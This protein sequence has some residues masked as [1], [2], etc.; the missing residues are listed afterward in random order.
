MHNTA[1]AAICRAIHWSCADAPAATARMCARARA[2]SSDYAGDAMARA[3]SPA[4]AAA[5]EALHATEAQADGRPP[6]NFRPPS[7]VGRTPARGVACQPSAPPPRA[8]KARSTVLVSQATS[9]AQVAASP[10]TIKRR[11]VQQDG[12]SGVVRSPRQS[13]YK[14]NSTPAANALT[15][16]G[17]ISVRNQSGNPPCAAQ[18]DPN[19]HVFI[20]RVPRQGVAARSLGM[21]CC[22]PGARCVSDAPR[23]GTSR[24]KGRW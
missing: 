10:G 20:T 5:M 3:C 6:P 24:C 1:K 12:C 16:R 2:T 14:C 15:Y 4:W 18:R 23:L 17:R 8:G 11:H 22:R 7:N 9:R 21:A 19:S 13:P